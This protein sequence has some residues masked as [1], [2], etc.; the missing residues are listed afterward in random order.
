MTKVQQECRVSETD[1]SLLA[2]Q[3]EI[4]FLRE[5]LESYRQLIK[6]LHSELDERQ[7][8][9]KELEEE[10]AQTNK[11]LCQALMSHHQ[12]I[13]QVKQVARQIANR[14]S[15]VSASLAALINSTYGC[16]MPAEALEGEKSTANTVL[17]PSTVYQQIL[18][19]SRNLKNHS[20]QLSIQ[21]KELG[22]QFVSKK[23]S[24]L[25][26]QQEVASLTKLPQQSDGEVVMKR[27][28]AEK[29]RNEVNLI[30]LQEHLER[31]RELTNKA[32]E[33]VKSVKSRS[34]SKE[35]FEKTLS[36]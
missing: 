28:K 33:Y 19:N 32:N 31:N 26:L 21:F 6:N 4:E 5:Q 7:Q 11:E 36:A 13:A 34:P 24:F 9:I 14:K 2:A 17:L 1:P 16:A 10:L 25:R 12:E 22:L 8:Q 15:S 3:E 18:A 27:W 30:Q 35:N 23:A 20:L 29:I